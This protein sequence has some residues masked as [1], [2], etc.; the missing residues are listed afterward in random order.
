[1]RKARKHTSDE[2]GR[3]PSSGSA[4]AGLDGPVIGAPGMIRTDA[5]VEDQAGPAPHTESPPPVS[6]G[7]L[8][9]FLLLMFL[10]GAVGVSIAHFVFHV[11]LTFTPNTPW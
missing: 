11:A 2:F 5:L 1:M 7:R 6:V 9:L 4:T 8:G 3:A 10:L